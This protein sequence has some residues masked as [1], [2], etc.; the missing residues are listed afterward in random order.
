M[1]RARAKAVAVASARAQPQ[2]QDKNHLER[3]INQPAIL[4]TYSMAGCHFLESQA[5]SD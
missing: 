2:Q 1:A 5:M 3:S 4:H